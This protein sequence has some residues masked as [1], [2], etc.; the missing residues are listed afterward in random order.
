MALP[1]TAPPKSNQVATSD[2]VERLDRSIHH[3]DSTV[4][5]LDRDINKL[6]RIVNQLSGRIK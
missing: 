5:K 1:G 6:I 2:E 3:L 4:E